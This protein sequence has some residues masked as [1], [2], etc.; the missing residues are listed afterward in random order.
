MG[1][2]T[3]L[4]AAGK[5]KVENGTLIISPYSQYLALGPYYL[6]IIFFVL[7]EKGYPISFENTHI[8]DEKGDLIPEVG[9]SN[10]RYSLHPVSYYLNSTLFPSAKAIAENKELSVVARLSEFFLSID[11]EILGVKNQ[12]VIKTLNTARAI[13]KEDIID[14][15]L[16]LVEANLQEEGKASQKQEQIVAEDELAIPQK[17]PYQRYE[18]I[19][20]HVQAFQADSVDISF[21][22]A[23]LLSWF[24]YLSALNFQ[25]SSKLEDDTALTTRQE[26]ETCL[27]KIK[28]NP[29]ILPQRSMVEPDGSVPSF[30]K[31]YT[32]NPLE[33][34]IALL[35]DY[36]KGGFWGRFFAGAW[37]RHHVKA[38]EA[39]LEKY[40]S[41][42]FAD[43]LSIQDVYQE[44]F[45]VQTPLV[46]HSGKQGTLFAR[47]LFCAKLEIQNESCEQTL[48]T[49]SSKTSDEL[50]VEGGSQQAVNVESL[51]IAIGEPSS[52]VS[53][54]VPEPRVRSGSKASFYSSSPSG[55]DKAFADSDSQSLVSNDRQVSPT[56]A[57][58]PRLSS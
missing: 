20:A 53:T 3:F 58:S 34:C 7:Q 5:L 31:F 41:G 23:E 26:I 55:S 28:E 2:G 37:K 49:T 52:S 33:T 21:V 54:P 11:D 36:T 35:H 15:L 18:K 14:F 38:V 50:E 16:S 17:T 57:G 27:K 40:E 8:V 30:V 13:L 4:K 25:V 44:L 10:R 51:P 32:E 48:A 22:P 24:Y 19:M 6:P 46:E 9:Y 43:K 39:F 47:L 42:Q 45:G 12:R 1:C 56:A 29:S